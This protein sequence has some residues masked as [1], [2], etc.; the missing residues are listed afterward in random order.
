MSSPTPTTPTSKVQTAFEL[1]VSLDD[2]IEAVRDA[3]HAVD[4]VIDELAAALDA[5]DDGDNP[6]SVRDGVRFMLIDAR[7]LRNDFDRY[8]FFEQVSELEEE[9]HP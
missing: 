6:E 8:D 3:I 5:L 1:K 7:D 4:V 2:R 9:H